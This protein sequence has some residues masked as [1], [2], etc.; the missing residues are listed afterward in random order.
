ME[1]TIYPA[2]FLVSAAFL[3]LWMLLRKQGAGNIAVLSFVA[4]I[5]MTVIASGLIDTMQ[6][7]NDIWHTCST[8]LNDQHQ[9]SCKIK[10]GPA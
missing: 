6:M 10:I 5:I 3:V 8:A 1:I 2:L 9:A 4:A 7:V